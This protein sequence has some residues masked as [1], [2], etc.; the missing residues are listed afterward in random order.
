MWRPPI[1]SDVRKIFSVIIINS[2]PFCI[3]Y[4][5]LKYDNSDYI[6]I[7]DARCE[8][9]SDL[10]LLRSADF[11]PVAKYSKCDRIEDARGR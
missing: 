11:D 2:D 6:A 3:F 1:H 8:L 4:K 7:Y 10:H 9:L 5:M